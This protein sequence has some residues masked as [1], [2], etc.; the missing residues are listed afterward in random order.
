[1]PNDRA[2]PK[3]FLRRC[4]LLLLEERADHGYELVERLRPFGFD[5]SD[6]GGVYRTLRGMETEEVVRSVWEESG[7]GPHRRRYELTPAGRAELDRDAEQLSQTHEILFN[8]LARY[9]RVLS[10]RGRTGRRPELTPR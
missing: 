3:Q 6:P 2:L 8:F 10:Q 7:C 5:G 9:Y 1:M 4:L